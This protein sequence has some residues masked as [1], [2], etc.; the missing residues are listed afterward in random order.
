M[1]I[2]RIQRDEYFSS[3]CSL[4]MWLPRAFL[5]EADFPQSLQV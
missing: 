5:D 3:L 4:V 2:K 1:E